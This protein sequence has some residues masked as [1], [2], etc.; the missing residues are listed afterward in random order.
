MKYDV[1]GRKLAASRQRRATGNDLIV[2]RGQHPYAGAAH[3]G[4][5]TDR[6]TAADE[7]D[8]GIAFGPCMV[9]HVADLEGAAVRPQSRERTPHAAAADRVERYC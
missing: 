9:E 5:A 8:R 1:A 7:G 4:D 3:F 2:G 6:A